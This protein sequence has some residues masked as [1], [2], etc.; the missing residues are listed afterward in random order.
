M[1]IG[2]LPGGAGLAGQ[3]RVLLQGV[4]NSQART[5]VHADDAVPR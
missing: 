2:S 5:A 3:V 4:R 1:C